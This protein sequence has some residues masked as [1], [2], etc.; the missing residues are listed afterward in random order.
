MENCIFCKIVRGEIAS[1]KVYDGVDSIAFIDLSPVNKGHVLAIP[2]KHI[3][4]MASADD[5]T[6]S[7]IFRVSRD[8]MV[9]IKKNL[10]CD[11]VQISIIGEQVPHF[12]IHLIPRYHNDNLPPWPTKKYESIDEMVEYANKINS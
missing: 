3:E 10:N 9:K 12:H 11:Y 6:I 5:D 7:S 4:N 8:L 1:T 2:K